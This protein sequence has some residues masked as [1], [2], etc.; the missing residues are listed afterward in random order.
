M[1]LRKVSGAN[2]ARIVTCAPTIMGA[3]QLTRIALTW[4]SGSTSRQWSFG[5]SLNRSPIEEPI[6]TRFAWSSITPLG[7][8][9][10]PLV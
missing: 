9:V 6:A 3:R 5:P 8:P 4:N 2:L 7:R 10:E 1:A